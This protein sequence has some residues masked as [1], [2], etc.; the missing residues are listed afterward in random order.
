[1]R[2]CVC[3]CMCVCVYVMGFTRLRVCVN[4]CVCG[5]VCVWPWQ[6]LYKL[7]EAQLS[8]QYHYDFKLRALKSVLVMAGGLKRGSPEFDESTIL[9]RALRDMNMPKFIFADV[10][11]FAG[12]ITDLFPGLDCPRVRYPDFNG[13]VESVLRDGRADLVGMAR[14]LLADPDWPVKVR[15]GRADAVVRTPRVERRRA[16]RWLYVGD[17]VTRVPIVVAFFAFVEF[18]SCGRYSVM[19]G[20]LLHATS[21]V[22]MCARKMKSNHALALNTA[23]T[24]HLGVSTFAQRAN[25]IYV[26]TPSRIRARP[27]V[28]CRRHR[29]RLTL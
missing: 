7:A 18:D 1:M 27:A 25:Y 28:Q 14:Q 19:E 26:C 2:A 12:L 4:I 6:V 24:V 11:L 22:R 9:M 8:K 10:P 13:A 15:A 5:R 16:E 29:P 20:S 21:C 17:F 23:S 3:V